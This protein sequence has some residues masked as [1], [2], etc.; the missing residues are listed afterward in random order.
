MHFI[1]T[2]FSC[3]AIFLSA[4]TLFKLNQFQEPT[5]KSNENQKELTVFLLDRAKNCILHNADIQ[6]KADIVSLINSLDNYGTVIEAG[7]DDLRSKYTFFFK[8]RLSTS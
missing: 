8:V 6:G 4:F 1:S 3:V 2:F 7:S 5:F